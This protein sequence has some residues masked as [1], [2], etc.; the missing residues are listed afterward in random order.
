[1]LPALGTQSGIYMRA[2][3]PSPQQAQPD[4]T[5]L[6][7]CEHWQP[8]ALEQQEHF[9]DFLLNPVAVQPQPV[10]PSG[11]AAAQ[12]ALFSSLGAAAGLVEEQHDAAAGFGTV[13]AFL[14][15]Q[16]DEA[17]AS[18]VVIAATQGS[19]DSRAAGLEAHEHDDAVEKLASSVLHWQPPGAALLQVQA[20][21]QQLLVEVAAQ[22]L[23]PS[24]DLVDGVLQLQAIVRMLVVGIVVYYHKILIVRNEKWVVKKNHVVDDWG[25]RGP[26]VFK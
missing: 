3:S 4:A 25:M 6:E 2:I 10:I 24:L 22:E 14:L 23:E 16:Q 5:R 11:A 13:V 21:S 26:S 1:M 7:L 17:G 15:E 12:A 8:A 19:L 18:G 20:P 9:D